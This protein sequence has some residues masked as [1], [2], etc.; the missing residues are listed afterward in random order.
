MAVR[1]AS[2]ASKPSTEKEGFALLK[3]SADQ[4]CPAGAL[5][6]GTIYM[7]QDGE[8]AKAIESYKKIATLP[9][10]EGKDIYD[11][12][13]GPML[14]SD[15]V[16]DMRRETN[17]RN[18]MIILAQFFIGGAYLRDDNLSEAK[19]WFKMASDNGLS[20]ATEIVRTIEGME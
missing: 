6:L 12:M 20:S 13:G 8:E 9:M 5:T 4:R 11:Y 14:P 7:K 3:K 17:N 1:G 16:R 18:K 19:K 2:L 15:M 10:T